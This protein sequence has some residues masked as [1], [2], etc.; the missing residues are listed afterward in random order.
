MEFCENSKPIYL[1]IADRLCDEMASGV[2]ASGA[3]VPSVRETAAKM[4]VNFN[5]VMRTYE[6][7]AAKGIIANKRGVGYFVVENADEMIRREREET[8][9]SDE[10]QHFF[11]R[12][13]TIGVD[14]DQLES[15]YKDYLMRNAD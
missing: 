14:P 8:F 6:Y 5:T 1:Q 4:Q 12:L 3:R 10:L 13:R 11:A 7:L 15:L 9:F 2:Y